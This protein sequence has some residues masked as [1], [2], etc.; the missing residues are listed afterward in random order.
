M[1]LGPHLTTAGGLGHTALLAEEVGAN[2][3]QFFTRNPRGGAARAITDQEIE[4]WQ[5]E[6]QRLGLYPVVGHLPYTVN[7][8]APNPETHAFA[9]RILAEDWQ[10]MA[11]LGVEYLVV[12]P[13]SHGG[14]GADAGIDRIVAAIS[15]A[16]EKTNGPEMLLLETMAGQGSEVGGHLEELATILERL[17]NPPQVGVCLDSCHLFA[18]GHDLSTPEGVDRL[19]RELDRTVGLERVKASHLN[20]SKVELASRRD[21]HERIG[22]GRLGDNGIGAYVRNPFIARLPLLLETPVEDYR[23]YAQEIRR[24]LRLAGQQA[25]PAAQ[26]SGA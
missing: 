22:Q 9:A 21:R 12:H 23:E 2:T 26:A 17:G 14:A 6:R 19:L 13:G 18:A 24:V 15:T 3:F 4:E 16:L 25:G 8:A 20:D 5:K 10:R 11:L 1:R 7:L